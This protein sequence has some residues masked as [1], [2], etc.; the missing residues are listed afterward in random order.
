[1]LAD[2]AGHQLDMEKLDPQE[3][4]DATI[5]SFDGGEGPLT[6]VIAKLVV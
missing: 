4:L 5:A 1:M 3:I 2:Q 6:E